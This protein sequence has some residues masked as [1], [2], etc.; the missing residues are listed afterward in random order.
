MNFESFPSQYA[1]VSGGVQLMECGLSYVSEPVNQ[2]MEELRKYLNAELP[3]QYT[4]NNPSTR[5][6]TTQSLSGCINPLVPALYPATSNVTP[7]E[8]HRSII[9][10]PATKSPGN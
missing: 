6:S 7:K 3:S 4:F 10:H 9:N 8:H 5:L 1:Y 2:A